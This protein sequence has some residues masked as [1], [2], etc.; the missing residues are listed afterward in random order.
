MRGVPG[1][2]PRAW[3]RYCR[4]ELAYLFPRPGTQTK[5]Y[6]GAVIRSFRNLP[7]LGVR[8]APRD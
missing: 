2:K 1:E 4:R 8:D 3:L 7:L 6:T 5:E